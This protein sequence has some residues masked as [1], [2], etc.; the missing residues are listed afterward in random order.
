MDGS[1]CR[2]IVDGITLHLG[3]LSEHERGT[4]EGESKDPQGACS[5]TLTQGIFSMQVREDGLMLY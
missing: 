3:F 5:A 4:S 1:L 2:L